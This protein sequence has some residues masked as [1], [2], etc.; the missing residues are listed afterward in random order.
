MRRWYFTTKNHLQKNWMKNSHF[1]HQSENPGIVII[2]YRTQHVL[3]G[4]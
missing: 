3:G 4:I 2:I 1:V